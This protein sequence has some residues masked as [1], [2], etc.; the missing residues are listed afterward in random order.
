MLNTET[1]P[2]VIAAVISALG[3]TCEEEACLAVLAFAGHRADKVRLAVAQAV[4]IGTETI[5]AQNLVA[6][7][8]IELSRDPSDEVRDWATFQ[9]GSILELDS[10]AIREA[11][12]ERV[13][14]EYAD[15]R[16]EA[17]V[18]LALRKDPRAFA[19]TL[20]ML[21]SEWVY[22]LA[23]EAAGALA[24]PRFAPA[25]HAIAE[26]WDQGDALLDDALAACVDTN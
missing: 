18:G 16:N 13:N 15:A 21:T 11:L 1:D 9:L 5:A 26:W 3:H 2:A 19:P 6:Q 14:D 7:T 20:E 12:A 22:S 10:P 8:L 17:V 24:D 23:I 4:G 25:L